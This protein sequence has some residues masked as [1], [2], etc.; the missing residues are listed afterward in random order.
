MSITIDDIKALSNRTVIDTS[1][2]RYKLTK[3]LERIIHS[4]EFKILGF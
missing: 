1:N 4:P 2:E 3:D